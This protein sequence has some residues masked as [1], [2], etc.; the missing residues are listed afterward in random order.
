MCRSLR[1]VLGAMEDSRDFNHV[2]SD[3]INRVQSTS[4][5]VPGPRRRGST[6]ESPSRLEESSQPV[7]DLVMS[8][9]F[10]AR[11]SRFTALDGFNKAIFLLEVASNNVPYHLVGAE[12]LAGCTLGEASLKIWRELH[13]HGHSLRGNELESNRRLLMFKKR[14]R[15]SR[16]ANDALSVPSTKF[17][18]KRGY[19]CSRLPR[20]DRRV[21]GMRRLIRTQRPPVAA[22]LTFKPISGGRCP[23]DL[24]PRAPRDQPSFCPASYAPYTRSA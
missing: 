3:S 8:Q 18:V 16:L 20:C 22:G 1:P 23:G 11:Q 24:W 10:A 12:A 19:S 13:F 2:L 9:R 14:F 15:Q 21:E 5:C 6:T 7:A 17:I 4:R